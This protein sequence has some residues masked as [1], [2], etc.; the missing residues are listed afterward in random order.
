MIYAGIIGTQLMGPVRVPDAVKIT[1]TSYCDTL[2][3]ALIRRLD[4]IPLSLL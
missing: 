4:D 1:S 3:D 2:N